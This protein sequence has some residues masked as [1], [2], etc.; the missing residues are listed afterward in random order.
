MEL[1]KFYDL[2]EDRRTIEMV[3]HATLETEFGLKPEPALF[4]SPE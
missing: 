3:Q 1:V 4:G 2:A